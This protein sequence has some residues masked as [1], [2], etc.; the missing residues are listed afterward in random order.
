MMVR[1]RLSFFLIRVRLEWF[2]C[3]WEIELVHALS[4]SWDLQ[5]VAGRVG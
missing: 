5:L 1:V 3:E 2:T 4:F